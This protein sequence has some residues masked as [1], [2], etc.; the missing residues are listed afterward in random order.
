MTAATFGGLQG[1]GSL[2]LQNTSS[3]AVALSLGNN[4]QN[5]TYSGVLSGSGSLTKIGTGTL[6]LANTNTYTGGTTV[7]AGLL[8]ARVRRQPCRRRGFALTGG[9]SVNL[10]PPRWA[11]S[12]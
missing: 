8:A 2:V 1:S 11:C 12:R 3:A 4:G 10:A 6:S 9:G 5:T 7:T